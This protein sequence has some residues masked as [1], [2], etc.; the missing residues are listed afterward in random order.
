[1]SNEWGEMTISVLW[2][3]VHF[4]KQ[5]LENKSFKQKMVTFLKKKFYFKVKLLQ[6]LAKDNQWKNVSMQKT[7]DT[8]WLGSNFSPNPGWSGCVHFQGIVDQTEGQY[9]I[10]ESDIKEVTVL[11]CTFFDQDSRA[12]SSWQASQQ[13]PVAS[14]A[15]CFGTIVNQLSKVPELAFGD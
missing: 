14:L 11:S 12:C 13:L 3:T 10:R 6:G 7:T 8:I 5:P 9:D 15:C 2:A 1:M 4:P